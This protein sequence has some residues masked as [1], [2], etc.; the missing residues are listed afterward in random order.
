VDSN[1][2][3]ASRQIS[4]FYEV[5][6]KQIACPKMYVLAASHFLS[7]GG[8]TEAV[9]GYNIFTTNYG[10]YPC[11]TIFAE[12]TLF[13]HRFHHILPISASPPLPFSPSPRLPRA[14]MVE[15]AV[16]RVYIHHRVQ[17]GA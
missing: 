14:G 13:P 12:R 10:S 9:A 16:A 1:H 17:D 7:E 4:D 3:E 15:M 5:I 2:Q 11:P 8:L 6:M